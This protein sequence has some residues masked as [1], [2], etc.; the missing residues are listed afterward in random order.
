MNDQTL[1][2]ETHIPNTK[3]SLIIRLADI[4]QG[5]KRYGI[6]IVF[7]LDSYPSKLS[8]NSINMSNEI[9]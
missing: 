9:I 1:I 2:N 4:F 6:N 8:D 5:T 7:F 3:T